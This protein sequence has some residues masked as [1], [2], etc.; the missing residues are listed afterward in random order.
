MSRDPLTT[1]R[2]IGDVLDP[3][4]PGT[5]SFSVTY[6]TTEVK[7]GYELRPSAVN[8]KP[9]V[10]IGGDPNDLRTFYTL[11]MTD[12]DAP[13]PSDPTHRE[14]LHWMVTDIPAATSASLGRE[15]VSYEAP[16]P[17]LGIHR[18]V[19]VLFKQV[20]WQT[21]SP[22]SSRQNFNTRTFAQSCRLAPPLAAVFFNAKREIAPRTR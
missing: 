11:I 16:R 13:N 1:G 20:G 9:R 17:M 19:F 5:I 3:F 12:P 22:P 2:V 7:N 8:L 18:F 14:Y 10:E 6:S 21:V 4:T 15:L